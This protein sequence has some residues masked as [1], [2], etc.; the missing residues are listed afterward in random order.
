MAI[1]SRTLA[2]KGASLYATI[3]NDI[4]EKLDL[5]E[6]DQ[7][8]FIHEDGKDFAIIGTKSMLKFKSNELKKLAPGALGFMSGKIDDDE[9]D[10]IMSEIAKNQ[11]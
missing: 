4:A 1:G 2:Y 10:L 5:K 11:D 6:G 3:P 8:I 9:L 7:L